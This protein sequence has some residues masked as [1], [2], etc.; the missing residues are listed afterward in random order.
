MSSTEYIRPRGADERPDRDPT[1]DPAARDTAAQDTAAVGDATDA[2][3]EPY[4]WTDAKRYLWLLGL[5]P[6]MGL[7]LSMPFVIGFNG[8]GL[9]WAATAAWFLL[10]VLVYVAIPLGDL[11]VGADGQNP[12]DEVMDR[13]EADP[14]YR[15]CTYLYIPFQYASLIVAC[16]LWTA[17]DLSWLGYDGG[18]GIAAS[19]GVA[20]TVAITGG[21]GINTAHELGH[22]IAGSEKWLSKVALATTGYG[23][24]FIEHNR[25]HHARVATPE[26][27]ASSRFGESFWAFLPRSVVG[28][29][30]SAWHLESER[31]GR[32]GKSPW[33]IR[34]DNL[35]AW[36]MTV[37]L[38][39][40]LIAVFGWEV[41]PWLLVQAVFGFSL[42]EVVN[43][44]E[45]YGL[46]RQKT[47]AGRY[48]R[49]R[50]EHSWNS[51][52]LVTNIFLYHLQRH[53]DHHANPM[54]R[55]QVLRSF[56][57]APQLPSGYATMMVLAYVPPLWRKVMDKRVLAHYDGD[58]TRANI[59]PS[60]RE[61]ILARHGVDAAA[62]GSTAV[63]EKVVADTDIAADQTSPT[64]EYVCPNCGHHYSEAAGE[65]REGFPPG[66]PWSAIPTT[67]RC[68]DC[69]VRDKVDFLPVK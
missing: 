53:S 24:F 28:S 32:L 15:W 33:T 8:L 3:V 49:C 45:H 63:A 35:N 12:P 67:W 29:A 52:H 14:F 9:G 27:P 37:V 51:D 38:F 65:P 60:K 1:T 58:I 55:Y 10:P 5:I 34:N 22:K 68:S 16:Y 20:W 54:R 50:P 47:S 69:G 46:K 4:A 17:Q 30:R 31:L 39:G 36:L 41:A 13:L 11:A 61:K 48:Q 7:F 40:G 42:L 57:Q 43:Y 56:E 64:G 18:L 6:A 26:D 19:I 66:T 59:Q 25:G 23:H 44:L 2:A 21:I 62:A